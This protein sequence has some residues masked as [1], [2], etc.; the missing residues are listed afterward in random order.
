MPRAGIEPARPFRA[1][2]FSYHYGFRHHLCLWSGLF[3]HRGAGPFRCV[4]SSLC[5]FLFSEAWL[6]I[7]IGLTRYGFLE[8]TTFYISLFRECTQIAALTNRNVLQGRLCVDRQQN[9]RKRAFSVCQRAR[10]S[11][12]CLPFH[13]QGKMWE[14]KDSKYYW[15]YRRRSSFLGRPATQNKNVELLSSQVSR[16]SG[17]CDATR[18]NLR[19]R[20]YSLSTNLARRGEPVSRTTASH[21]RAGSR[22]CQKTMDQ[23]PAAT[24]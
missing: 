22:A 9:R 17:T 15:K 20:H 16:F 4:V 2:G 18:P 12:S 24:T 11:P 7:A 6:K 14:C 5:T 10:I 21:Q 23:E 8:F 13:H 3:L 1:K 19:W